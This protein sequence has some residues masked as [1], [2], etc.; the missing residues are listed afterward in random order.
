MTTQDG[1]DKN[2]VPFGAVFG[3]LFFAL[4]ALWLLAGA[5]AEQVPL[6]PRAF[7]VLSSAALAVA[8]MGR[9]SWARWAGALGAIAVAAICIRLGAIDLGPTAL[10]AVLGALVATGL[11]LVPATGELRPARAALPAERGGARGRALAAAAGLGALGF[12]ASTWLGGDPAFAP[13]SATQGVAQASRKSGSTSAADRVPWTDFGSALARART[14]DKPILA[15]FVTGWCGYC[16]QMDRTTWRDAR[17]IDRLA[18]VVA[19][20]IDAEDAQERNGYS[21]R[22]LAERYGVEGYPTLVVLDTGGRVVARTSG[23]LPSDE[24][25]AWLDQVL[26]G[27]K[28]QRLASSSVPAS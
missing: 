20:R 2:G 9:R 28:T 24:L 3:A 21:G 8:L 18:G 19:T 17:V 11:L 6:V 15:T 12:A 23:Y 14:E 7:L 5:P 16:R 13:G 4:F 22:A 25:V 27:E 1:N 26:G 10:V